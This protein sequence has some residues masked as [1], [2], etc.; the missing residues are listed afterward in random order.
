MTRLLLSLMLALSMAPTARATDASHLYLL[1]RSLTDQLGGP[2]LVS[3]G[4]DITASGYQFANGT[5]LSLSGVFTGSEY[6]IDMSFSFSVLSNGGANYRRILEFKNLTSDNGLYTRIVNTGPGAVLNFYRTANG[7][8]PEVQGS[9]NVFQL[10]TPAR[11]TLTRA[12]SGWVTGYVN[13][14]QQFS[15]NDSLGQSLFSG[16]DSIAY[17]FKDEN[18]Q[19][20]EHPSGVVSYIR[21]YST[22]LSGAQVAALTAPVPEPETYALMLAGLG[23]VGVM[24]R[25]RKQ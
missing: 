21:T 9:D 4:G 5:G 20:L 8:P 17:F 10:G 15:F 2:S 12:S 18:V 16:P 23:L 22:A 14:A 11:V 24:A 25:R 19:G 7:G 6:T 3:Q 13:G 1:D